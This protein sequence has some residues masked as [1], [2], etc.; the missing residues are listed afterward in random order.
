MRRTRRDYVC[1]QRFVGQKPAKHG[2]LGSDWMS[3]SVAQNNQVMARLRSDSAKTKRETT[4][5]TS[6]AS[7]VCKNGKSGATVAKNSVSSKA[8]LRS[9]KRE[10]EPAADSLQKSTKCCD[11]S[12]DEPSRNG[13][14]FDNILDVLPLQKW[15]RPI[16]CWSVA[17]IAVKVVMNQW[18]LLKLR[19]TQGGF[20]PN[21]GALKRFSIRGVNGGN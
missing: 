19:N 10:I 4:R 20:V 8:S 6:S 15:L 12:T 1:D 14:F 16:F 2:F 7:R 9:V 13:E 21:S 18:C 5:K 17:A 3:K 11:K